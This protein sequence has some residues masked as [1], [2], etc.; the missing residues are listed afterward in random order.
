MMTAATAFEATMIICWGVSWPSAVLKTYRTKNVS[1][2]SIMF[3]WLIFAGYVSGICFKLSQ[4]FAE[5]SLNHVIWLYV[6]NFIWVTAEV[7]LY[8][9]YRRLHDNQT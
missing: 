3:L 5:N 7:V 1:G 8:Y 4:F 6:F 2:I 9:R